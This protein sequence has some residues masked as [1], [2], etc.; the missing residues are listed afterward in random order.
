MNNPLDDPIPNPLY[1]GVGTL[2]LSEDLKEDAL[3]IGI[4]IGSATYLAMIQG[5][6]QPTELDKTTLWFGEQETAIDYCKKHGQSI[7]LKIDLTGY[8]V[9]RS[10]MSYYT[11]VPIPWDRVTYSKNNDTYGALQQNQSLPQDAKDYSIED[12]SDDDL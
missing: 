10:G 12:D 6:R 7:L 2:R 3:P 8:T 1:K 11:T 9:T 5:V 4:R